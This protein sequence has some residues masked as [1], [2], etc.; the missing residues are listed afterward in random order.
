M[1]HCLPLSRA[2][3]AVLHSVM[4][5]CDL[6]VAIDPRGPAGPAE[7]RQQLAHDWTRTQ[8]AHLE[9]RIDA[10]GFAA[11][12]IQ[13]RLRAVAEDRLAG[14]VAAI[15]NN[16]RLRIDGLRERVPA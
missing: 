14:D 10:D 16:L 2:E 12:W 15:A 5:P 13:G 11:A 3:Q 4:D 9:L 6:G 1:R 8:L 7:W